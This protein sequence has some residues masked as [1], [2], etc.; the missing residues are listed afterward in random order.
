MRISQTLKLLHHTIKQKKH[1]TDFDITIFLRQLATLTAAGVPIVKSFEILEKSQDKINLRLLI[2]S[3]RKEILT[4]RDLYSSL[5]SYSH[6]F[7][8]ITCQLIKVGEH[9][10]KIEAMLTMIADNKEKNLTTKN[11]LKQALFYPCIIVTIAI[12]VTGSMFIFIIPRFAE[13]FS[14]ANIQLPYFTIWLFYLA[15]E[16]HNHI[17][18]IMM[19]IFFLLLLFLPVKI[20][21]HVKQSILK[22]L[23]RFPLIRQYG[24]KIIYARFARTLAMTFAAGL[25]ISEALKLTTY[26]CNDPVFISNMVKLRSTVNSGLQLYQAMQN[27]SYFPD[28]MVQ[29][30]KIGEESGMLEHLLNKIA[31]IFES[32]IDHF[33]RQ[34]SQLL[35]PLIMVVL[36]VL[37]GGLVIGM[38][39]PIFKLGSIL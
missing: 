10:G 3:L 1:I 14:N 22:H 7:D 25:P 16:S 19:P 15:T 18:I 5:R 30:V 34:F 12:A 20:S 9:T 8:E 28:L 37:I 29:M 13:L 31:S 38:Y 27:L 39:L 11:R 24:Q 6:Y 21:L 4:G 35:E 2:Y 17:Y 36:G 33:I 23:A 32:D 26:T